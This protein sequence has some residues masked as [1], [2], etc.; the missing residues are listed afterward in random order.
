M[1]KRNSVKIKKMLALNW[2][3]IFIHYAYTS[4]SQLFSVGDPL[5]LPFNFL[6][7]HYAVMEPKS[8]DDLSRINVKTLF[9]SEIT[10]S[11][12]KTNKFLFEKFK[13]VKLN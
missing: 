8:F 9:F 13:K 6:T 7:D 12:V 11:K 3:L 4:A 1:V 5:L 2:L 10:I